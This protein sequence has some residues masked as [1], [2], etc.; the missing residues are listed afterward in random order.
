[1]RKIELTKEEQKLLDYLLILNKQA[2]QEFFINKNI[3]NFE[4]LNDLLEE[5]LDTIDEDLAYRMLNVLYKDRIQEKAPSTEIK[6]LNGIDVDLPKERLGI[7]LLSIALRDEDFF[8]YTKTLATLGF[9]NYIN[10]NM[11]N[12][13]LPGYSLMNYYFILD[14]AENFIG[15]ISDDNTITKELKEDI[16]NKFLFLYK[17]LYDE[18]KTKKINQT[19]CSIL[20]NRYNALKNLYPNITDDLKDYLSITPFCQEAITLLKINDDGISDWSILIIG[21]HYLDN[22]LEPLTEQG[23]N[24]LEE[25]YHSIERNIN[26]DNHMEALNYIYDS[27]T[28]KQ[29]NF[30][31][32]KKLE[33]SSHNI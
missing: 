33:K 27:I 1:M 29:E 11:L 26:L 5:K 20:A 2:E 23:A 7:L 22:L 9:N 28:D 30:D 17:D 3:D 18:L 15:K 14:T 24:N 32:K 25:K 13:Y 21:K 31:K 10:T 16:I 4:M 12:R 19:T 6:I 8:E